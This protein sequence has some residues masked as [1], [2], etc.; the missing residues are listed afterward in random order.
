MIIE[1]LLEKMYSLNPYLNTYGCHDITEEDI[2]A[3]VKVLKGEQ[4]TGGQTV[5]D[6]EERVTQIVGARYAVACSNGTTALHLA[7]QAA[8]LK[9]GD[10]VIV[11]SMTFVATANAA[12]YCGT[13]VIFSDVS[14]ENGLME[15]KHFE[16]ALE[17]CPK[18]PVAVYPVHLTGQPVNLLE[19][20]KIADQY[21]IKIIEDG[22]HAFGT[23][24]QD[25]NGIHTIGDGYYSDFMAFSFHPV[26]NIATGEG[27]LITT[28]NHDH[29]EVMKCLRS[30]GI[31][32]EP[33][34]FQRKEAACDQNGHG[35]PW[36]YEMI[37]IGYNYRLTDI[38]AALGISQLTRLSIFKEHRSNLKKAY[39][40]LLAPYH[41]YVRPIKAVPNANP[42]WHLFSILIDFHALNISR[43]EVMNALSARGIV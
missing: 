39:D 6:F 24:Y 32:R 10:F 23:D 8:G 26:K 13:E 5:P 40:T 22:C 29:Y 12:R 18:T 36:Y 34:L 27:G 9:P 17:R 2:Q 41:E 3:V 30:H 31:I 35:N 20:K 42:C 16:E 21:K 14:P 28:N 19:I 4:L 33:H 11:P 38:Q 1:R 43:S 15:P 25:H 37:D 7:S